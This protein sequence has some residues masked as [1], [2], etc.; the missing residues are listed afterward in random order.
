MSDLQHTESIRD[1]L[2][3]AA[4]LISAAEAEA[5]EAK[6]ESSAEV[7]KEIQH[8]V[9]IIVDACNDAIEV[10]STHI[11]YVRVLNDWRGDAS[12]YKLDKF[13]SHEGYK[14]DHVV[15]SRVKI[16][17]FYETYMF[18]ATP[19]GAIINWIEMPGSMRHIDPDKSTP[20]TVVDS[21]GWKWKTKEDQ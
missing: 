5:T 14:S 20:L 8:L 18:L 2:V 16:D 17:N 9:K 15:M 4:E 21:L 1:L 6:Y 12:L 3:N 10:N 19:D 13:V 11:E 7:L